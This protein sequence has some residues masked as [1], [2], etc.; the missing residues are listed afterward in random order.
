VIDEAAK[1][2][3]KEKLMAGPYLADGKP[4]RVFAIVIEDEGIGQKRIATS[5]AM[6]KNGEL[7]EQKTFSSLCIRNEKSLSE[8]DRLLHEKDK[9]DCKEILRRQRIDL[10]VVSANSL[11]APKIWELLRELAENVK[12]EAR[13][14][15]DRYA[16]EAWVSFGSL[17]IPKLFA[18]S[19]RGK[20]LHPELRV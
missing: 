3:K 17:E 2:Y 13:A 12:E 19:V 10:I 8:E 9:L 14:G 11:V 4:P 16:K 7:L 20:K 18:N 15:D 1:N 5:V 6:D